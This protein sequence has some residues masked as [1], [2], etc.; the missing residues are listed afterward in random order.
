MTLKCMHMRVGVCGRLLRWIGGEFAACFMSMSGEGLRGTKLSLSS[1]KPISFSL[2][3]FSSRSLSLC[4]LPL[5]WIKPVY[6]IYISWLEKS[7]TY[8]C[9]SLSLGELAVQ[10]E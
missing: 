5:G 4:V 9:V 7:C 1:P 2:F 3:F 8:P 6:D 10:K